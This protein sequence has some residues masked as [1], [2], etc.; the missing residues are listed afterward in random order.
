MATNDNPLI[1]QQ[2]I[3]VDPNFFLPP[4][5]INGEYSS[6]DGPFSEDDETVGGTGDTVVE[7]IDESATDG[8]ITGL[9]PPDTVT[10]FSQ[11][12]RIAPDGRQVIDVLLDVET[13]EGA[14]DYEV[15]YSRS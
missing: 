14:A 15:R 3:T 10:V 7:V 4:S 8:G 12:V 5:L 1:S 11:T 2:P 6:V 9:R 13:V